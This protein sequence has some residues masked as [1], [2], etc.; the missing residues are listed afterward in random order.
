VNPEAI[1]D[2]FAEP[3]T[4]W[5]TGAGWGGVNA[6]RKVHYRNGNQT[7]MPSE[8]AFPLVLFRL[9]F[10]SDQ[11]HATEAIYK[12]SVLQRGPGYGSQ[13]VLQLRGGLRRRE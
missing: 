3:P 6:D 2:I 10:L 4:R 5:G 11:I 7:V 1:L 9:I 13:E 12:T 8:L